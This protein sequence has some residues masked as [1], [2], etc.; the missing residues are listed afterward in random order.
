MQK[1]SFER[2]L[3][4]WSTLYGNNSSKAAEP[5]AA[6]ERAQALANQ[7]IV[8]VQTHFVRDD[9]KGEFMLGI[10]NYAA[11]NYN[12]AMKTGPG[13]LTLDDR[14]RRVLRHAESHL[15]LDR[16]ARPERRAHHPVRRPIP[17]APVV[18]DLVGEQK[19]ILERLLRVA[20][21]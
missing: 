9:F 3:N 7:Y 13:G 6:T 14:M 18:D 17:A 11:E 19:R 8:D 2:W 21:E 1:G 10:L 15:V 16:L 4:I 12:P 20:P 5:A